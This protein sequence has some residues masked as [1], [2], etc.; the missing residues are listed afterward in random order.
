MQ[1]KSPFEIRLEL[2]QL[3]NDY[4]WKM[5]DQNST[6]VKQAVTTGLE[7]GKITLEEVNKNLPTGYT[8]EDVIQKAEDM[9]AFVKR[10]D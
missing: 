4:F 5:H 7:L 2:L 6:L 10:K 3:A 1:N 9:Y 8:I